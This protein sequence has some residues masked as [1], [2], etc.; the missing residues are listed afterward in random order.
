ME[1]HTDL[2]RRMQERAEAVSTTVRAIQ[3]FDRALEYAVALCDAREACQ[4]L[5][6]G[7]EQ[8]LSAPSETLCLS[9]QQKILAAPELEESAFERLERLCTGRGIRLVR[10]GLRNHLSGIDVG[11]SMVDYGLADTGTLVLRSTSEELRLATMVSEVHV[12]IL[13]LARIVP[14][15]G[16][17]SKELSAL[18]SPSGQGKGACLCFITGPS[19]TADIER[20]LTIGVHGPLELHLLLVGEG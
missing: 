9:K 3:D 7:C 16:A 4:L 8:R 12:A 19:R 18:V 6:T 2:V 13:P 5:P 17:L 15:A 11:V 14:D 20:V 1:A 10:S